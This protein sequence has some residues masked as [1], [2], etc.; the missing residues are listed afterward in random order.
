MQLILL[1]QFHAI[2]LRN[3]HL[4]PFYPIPY[5]VVRIHHTWIFLLSTSFQAC[6]SINIFKL[7]VG[8][9]VLQTFSL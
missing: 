5:F 4:E 7:A 2:K 9:G 6:F 8:P 1:K 3:L